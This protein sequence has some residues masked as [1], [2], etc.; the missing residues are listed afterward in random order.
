V[1]VDTVALDLVNTRRADGDVI[2][3]PDGLAAW[4]AGQG[5][6]VPAPD[7]P[8]GDD[9]V[10]A[11]HAV[12]G[13]LATLLTS[14][15]TGSRPSATALASLNRS[16]QSAA[17]YAALDWAGGRPTAVTTWSGSY[18][19]RLRAHL[20]TAAIGFLDNLDA[21]TLRQ[22]GAPDCVVL[23]MPT[24]PRRQWCSPACGNRV[25]VTRY[26]HRHKTTS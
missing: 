18:P 1:T 16:A 17:R 13:N 6:R 25:R 8:V 14:L 11:A 24:H 5:D 21:D 26:Y 2:A 22:C 19:A 4:L 12:R 15:R 20:A 23:F 3:T 7:G 9:A 10:A